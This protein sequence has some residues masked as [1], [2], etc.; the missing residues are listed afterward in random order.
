[1]SFNI[2][3]RVWGG[4]INPLIKRKLMARQHLAARNPLKPDHKFSDSIDPNSDAGKILTSKFQGT[5]V[6]LDEGAIIDYN[7]SWFSG[8]ADLSSRKPFARMWIA[9]DVI[10]WKA[11]D[12]SM[13]TV[14]KKEEEKKLYNYNNPTVQFK[15]DRKNKDTWYEYKAESKMKRL[16]VVGNNQYNRT[17]AVNILDGQYN[18]AQ[19]NPNIKG[20]GAYAIK[21][22]MN[23]SGLIDPLTLLPITPSSVHAKDDKEIASY[24]DLF[25]PELLNNTFLS[26]VANIKSI[27]SETK[28]SLGLIKQTKVEFVVNNW[29]DFDKI[30]FK[31]FM[32]PG[33]KV[34]VDYGWD[35]A[36]LYPPECITAWDEGTCRDDMAGK[37]SVSKL[38]GQNGYV[39]TSLGDMRSIS[40]TV[41]GWNAEFQS[42]ATI[43]CSIELTSSNNALMGSNFDDYHSMFKDILIQDLEE[44]FI[45]K[46]FSMFVPP[47]NLSAATTATEQK[48]RLAAESGDANI[49]SMLARFGKSVYTDGVTFGKHS[50]E[51]D[52]WDQIGSTLFRL[53]SKFLSTNPNGGFGGNPELMK[54]GS[55]YQASLY[56][57]FTGVYY[58]LGDD[59]SGFSASNLYVTWGRFEDDIL[60]L[61]YG[62]GT[63]YEE[64]RGIYG[65][66]NSEIQW[67]SCD[68][69]TKWDSNLVDRQ[70]SEWTAQKKPFLIPSWWGYAKMKPLAWGPDEDIWSWSYKHKRHPGYVPDFDTQKNKHW[71]SANPGD[72]YDHEAETIEEAHAKQKL[73]GKKALNYLTD[74]MNLKRIPLR[75]VFIR[76]D[77]IK[78]ALLES[79]NI[80]E[81]VRYVLDTINE[82]SGDLWKWEIGSNSDDGD[83]IAIVDTNFTDVV[84]LDSDPQGE[85][86]DKLFMFSPYSPHTIV[87]DFTFSLETPSDEHASMLAIQGQ[88]SVGQVIPVSKVAD[89]QKWSQIDW[90]AEYAAGFKAGSPNSGDPNED[91]FMEVRYNPNPMTNF[92]NDQQKKARENF[93]INL[94]ANREA[95]LTSGRGSVQTI[96]SEPGIQLSPD[97]FDWYF[98]PR[99][100]ESTKNGTTTEA[101]EGGSFMSDILKTIKEGEGKSEKTIVDDQTDEDKENMVNNTFNWYTEKLKRFTFEN[102]TA[103]V[104]PAKCELGIYG[105]S[106]ILPGDCFRVDAVPSK[107]KESCFFQ[108]MQTKD[109]IRPDAWTTN[110]ET[111]FRVRPLVKTKLNDLNKPLWISKKNLN[112]LT[113]FKE[114]KPFCTNFV[115]VVYGGTQVKYAT[116]VYKFTC[117]ANFEQTVESHMPGV[118]LSSDIRDEKIKAIA[119]RV[120]PKEKASFDDTIASQEEFYGSFYGFA[121]DMAIKEARAMYNDY[122]FHMG[123]DRNEKHRPDVNPFADGSIPEHWITTFKSIE[124]LQVAHLIAEGGGYS[125]STIKLKNGKAIESVDPNIGQFPK[126]P[127][128]YFSRNW[129]RHKFEFKT[130]ESD[131]KMIKDRQYYL[132]VRKPYWYIFP[133]INVDFIKQWED[134]FG[135]IYGVMNSLFMDNGRKDLIDLGKFPNLTTLVVDQLQG[136]EYREFKE[137]KESQ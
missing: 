45:T 18:D 132:F 20:A 66:G 24:E 1:M 123:W 116:N 91:F 38:Y 81:A 35:T 2:N 32:Q 90:E 33:G 120:L 80:H 70:L 118:P 122:A 92:R 14:E 5:G 10:K 47:D 69:Y 73:P 51:I 4:D 111:Q 65:N 55:N 19:D 131:I 15:E 126:L 29:N 46:A 110:L 41:T 7:P 12:K 103:T 96:D 117:K 124:N 127:Q 94:N 77:V 107:Y 26:D 125:K 135:C 113:N 21:T 76:V 108:V 42:D 99:M 133:A 39:T 109:E 31:Y 40:G 85:K 64:K 49:L 59:K 106:A 121:K 22:T 98:S 23:S 74:K 36:H 34:V 86:F 83:Q 88:S 105:T 82:S 52:V 58:H 104:L 84:D 43:V 97:H 56:P 30:F 16:Y 68:S 6:N 28:G 48:W 62:F 60:N 9:M 89:R 100:S 72:D 53:A 17:T 11:T 95:M 54:R 75:E 44:M 79:N 25:P 61:T 129:H 119:L 78:D 27:T 136:R 101:I 93:L 50:D 137:K 112:G 13:T 114:L 115:P 3:K 130:F 71:T 63:T 87:K 102:Y 128:L 57:I 37:P 67:N 8:E 134:H